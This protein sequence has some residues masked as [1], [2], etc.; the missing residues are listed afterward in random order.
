[1]KKKS[2]LGHT[3]K[4]CCQSVFGASLLSACSVMPPADFPREESVDVERYMGAWYVIAHIPP[5]TTRNA[6]NA[7][8]RYKLSDNG[9]I[10]TV[11]TY[12]EGGFDGEQKVMH[13]TGFIIEQGNGAVWGMQFVWPIKMEYTIAYVD[14]E[15]QHTI[16]ARSRRDWVWIM[17]RTPQM[18]ETLYQRMV[19]RV[20]DLG[21]DWRKLRRMPQQ[22]LSQR[23]DLIP[24]AE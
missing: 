14:P 23:D 7:I 5:K 21:Y 2:G 15:Y 18:D 22:P 4:T 8:E 19:K 3:F 24:P 17:S 20:H 9:R 13:P 10:D 11:Y 16:V 1:M 12:R 6:Y